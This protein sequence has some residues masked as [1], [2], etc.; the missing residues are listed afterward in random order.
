M[1]FGQAINVIQDDSVWCSGLGVDWIHPS[2]VLVE[3]TEV[4]EPTV[5]LQDSGAGTSGQQSVG[6]PVVQRKSSSSTE[7]VTFRRNT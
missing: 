4:H 2:I 1:V 5:S 7:E 6:R 3:D